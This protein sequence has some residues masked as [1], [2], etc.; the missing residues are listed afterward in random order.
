MKQDQIIVH[1]KRV[2]KKGAAEATARTGK[3]PGEGRFPARLC[4]DLASVFELTRVP[5]GM[6]AADVR[7]KGERSI[8]FLDQSA[9]LQLHLVVPASEGA[10]ALAGA[11]FDTLAKLLRA[12]HSDAEHVRVTALSAGAGGGRAG[13]EGAGEKGATPR[14]RRARARRATKLAWQG[15]RKA[16]VWGGAAT[17]SAALAEPT[18]TREVVARQILTERRRA[19]E[20]AHRRGHAASPTRLMALDAVDATNGEFYVYLPLHFMRILLTRLR[21]APP[22]LCARRDGKAARPGPGWSGYGR[23]CSA[24]SRSSGS[25]SR[26]APQARREC[27]PSKRSRRSAGHRG[28]ATRRSCGR[29]RTA[30]IWRS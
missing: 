4:L 18:P 14:R 22:N 23:K 29:L 19:A 20:E 15:K 27:I 26:A 16:S 1:A 5:I 7:E 2:M 3:I 11:Y 28:R 8:A 6:S 12:V 25:A 30:S 17:M 24:A 13:G 10:A 9:G 21:L